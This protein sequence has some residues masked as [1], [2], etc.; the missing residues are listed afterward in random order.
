MLKY[1]V[2]KIFDKI[3]TW[4][5]RARI[6]HAV[7]NCFCFVLF[8][9]VFSVSIKNTPGHFYYFILKYNFVFQNKK[10]SK[11]IGSTQCR[12]EISQALDDKSNKNLNSGARHLLNETYTKFVIY[13][14]KK[15][16]R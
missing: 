8:C 10:D 14:Y 1:S 12:E 3:P 7:F 16:S 9:F 11:I 13:D 15:I 6:K 5:H 2:N 4:L